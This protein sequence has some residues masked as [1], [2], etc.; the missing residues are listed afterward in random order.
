MANETRV[1]DAKDVVHIYNEDGEL[2][3]TEFFDGTLCHYKG[4]E[5]VRIEWSDGAVW[6]YRN[7]KLVR[8]EYPDG[9]VVTFG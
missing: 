5:R 3:R 8:K 6:H 9:K 2:V 4:G 7:A 1:P